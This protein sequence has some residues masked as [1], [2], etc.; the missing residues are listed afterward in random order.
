MQNLSFWSSPTLLSPLTAEP[1]RIQMIKGATTFSIGWWN[2]GGSTGSRNLIYSL[3]RNHNKPL[4]DA[5]IWS[6]ESDLNRWY[7]TYKVGALT[8]YAILAL[9]AEIIVHSL[10]QICSSFVLFTNRLF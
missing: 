6:Q 7:P 4:Y 10:E 1:T 5:P 8:N 9:F 2:F 3:Q